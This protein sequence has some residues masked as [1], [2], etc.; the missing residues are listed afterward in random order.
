MPEEKKS[1]EPRSAVTKDLAMDHSLLTVRRA[2]AGQVRDFEGWGGVQL[3]PKPL[4]L[5]DLNGQLLFYDFAVMDANRMVGS[6]KASAS[7]IIGSPVVTVEFGPRGWDAG[8]ATKEAQKKAKEQ[9]PRAKIKKTEVVCYCYPKV[10]VRVDVQLA[11]GKAASAIY[12]ASDYSVVG[13][14][15]ADETE[16]S[17]GYSFYQE[18]AEP[19]AEVRERRWNLAER[20]LEAARSA[21]PRVLERAIRTRDLADV[22]ATLLPMQP[23]ATYA[24]AT[25]SQKVIPY[26]PRCSTHECFALYAQQTS[27][28]CAVATGQ[29]ILDFYRWYYTQDQIAAAMGTGAGGTSNTGQVTGYETLSKKCLDATYDS[30]ANWTE[31]KAEIDQGRPLKSGIAGHA[32]ACAG[33]KK[34]NIFLVGQTP[35]KWLKIYDPWPWNANIC[36][37]GKI[38]WED[39]DAVTHTNFIYVRHRSTPCS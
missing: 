7:R 38:Y 16:G 28:Y 39:W 26:S 4:E 21:T 23:V 13:R 10:G 32:R 8:A 15:G 20:E 34:Q 22:R 17:I 19:E 1:R 9:F 37:G 36:S 6:V 3:D 25:Y 2:W 12:D 27:V 29:M 33:W 18:I 30:T 31:A 5:H 24:L 11:D 14:F 35:K